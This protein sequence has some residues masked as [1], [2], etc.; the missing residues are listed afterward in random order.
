[1]FTN[2]LFS[3]RKTHNFS[4]EGQSPLRDL[5]STGEGTP[6]PR[7]CP[8][9]PR[10]RAFGTASTP[11][12]FRPLQKFLGRPLYRP[13]VYLVVSTSTVALLSRTGRSRCVGYRL[14]SVICDF[15]CLSVCVRVKGK[16]RLELSTPSWYTYISWQSLGGQ[17]VKGR[18]HRVMKTVTV[19]WF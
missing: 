5:T 16:K 18:G 13:T 6:L 19:A 4:G 14:M 10:F 7:P 11:S 3:H 17:K 12:A 9:A 8:T 15:V 2:T 1:M